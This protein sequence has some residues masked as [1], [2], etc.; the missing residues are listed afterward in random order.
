MAGH[1]SPGRLPQG[2]VR[3]R[4]S[5]LAD[6]RAEQVDQGLIAAGDH[7]SISSRALARIFSFPR[8]ISAMLPLTLSP[9][10]C[11]LTSDIM[12]SDEWLHEFKYDGWRLLARKD[13]KTVR[14]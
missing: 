1:W 7:N 2:G 6:Y 14:L 12:A 8:A 9:Q 13:A 5:A 4:P 11:T 10:L 3:H